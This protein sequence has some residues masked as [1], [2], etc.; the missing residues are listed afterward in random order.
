MRDPKR[1]DNILNI[2][3]L[4]WT[5]C[6]DMRLCQLIANAVG[7]HRDIFYIEDEELLQSLVHHGIETSESC[8]DSFRDWEKE[9]D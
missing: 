6:S 7:H 5:D 4:I 1:I 3:R 8:Q 2:I 9:K